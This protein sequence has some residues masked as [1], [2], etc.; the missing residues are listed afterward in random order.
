MTAPPVIA[1]AK[2]LQDAHYVV[3]PVIGKVPIYKD[4]L[5]KPRSAEQVL[6]DLRMFSVT[7]IGFPGGEINHSVVPLD[8]DKPT[9]WEW[10][11]S[12]CAAAGIDPSHFP[13]V[14]T[15]GKAR[16]GGRVPGRHVYVRDVRGALGNSA[17]KLREL[18]I[19]V[20]GHGHVVLPPSPHPDGGIYKWVNGGLTDWEDVPICPDFVYEAIEAKP[21]PSAAGTHTK[22]T[23]DQRVR[24][25]CLAALDNQRQALAAERSGARNEALNKAAHSL[26]R[27]RSKNRRMALPARDSHSCCGRL[28]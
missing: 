17:G 23:A 4:W 1:E 18:G 12:S 8:F 13:T 21:A 7:G 5:V 25:Y 2:R 6:R 15:P 9:G 22:A 14:I 24:R 11:M 16:N 27:L 28:N 26:G 19:D 3:L 10:W 20:R